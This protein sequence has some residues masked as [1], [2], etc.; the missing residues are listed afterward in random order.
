MKEMKDRIKKLVDKW[1][2]S[3]D[4]TERAQAELLDAYFT[5]RCN[6]PDEDPGFGKAIAEPKTTQDIMDELQPMMSLSE[7]VVVDYMRVHAFGFTTLPD[8]SVCW[9]VWR[10]VGVDAMT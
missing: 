2:A 9:A 5:F 7:S 8:G 6:L 10:F 1:L 3:L 4:E